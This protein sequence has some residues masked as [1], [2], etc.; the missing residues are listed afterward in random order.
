MLYPRL[1]MQRKKSVMIVFGSGGHTSEMI[2]VVKH[3]P[4]RHYGPFFFIVAGTDD[5]TQKRVQQEN[6]PFGDCVHWFI[7]TRAREV[8]QS[9]LSSIIT[10]ILS[11]LQSIAVLLTLKPDLMLV[12]GPG[13]CVPP[14]II[15]TFLRQSGFLTTSIIFLESICRVNSLSMSGRILYL[16]CDKFVVQWQNLC[17]D[18]P[19][20]EYIG[21]IC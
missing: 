16:V 13:T 8:K 12:N 14:C 3:F 15:A 2:S 18:Y 10:S 5:Y 4:T 9:F 21:R 19:N 17:E 20:A 6:L 7:I 11:L 1:A